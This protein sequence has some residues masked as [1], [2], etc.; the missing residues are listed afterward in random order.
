MAY[1]HRS[2]VRT[3]QAPVPGGGVVSAYLYP[4]NDAAAVVEAPNYSVGG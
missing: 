4:T 3:G 2:V 1:R